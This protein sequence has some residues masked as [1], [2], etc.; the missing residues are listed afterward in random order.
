VHQLKKASHGQSRFLRTRCG[1]R[2][3]AELPGLV[4]SCLLPATVL[5]VG[6]PIVHAGLPGVG[7]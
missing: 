1:T 4:A 3:S 5:L 7:T 2:T 6:A